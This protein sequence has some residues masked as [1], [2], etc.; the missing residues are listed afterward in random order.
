MTLELYS[1]LK[2]SEFEISQSS[3]DE[4]SGL[5][6]KVSLIETVDSDKIYI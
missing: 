6:I 3:K 1:K 2:V 4:L 5:K